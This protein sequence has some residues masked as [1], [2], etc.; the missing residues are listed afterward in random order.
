MSDRFHP[1]SMGA[2]TDWV[3]DELEGAGSV[4]GIPRELFFRP[5]P[6]DPFGLEV[7]GRSLESP[8]GVAAGPHTQM[9]Q[10]IVVAWLCGARFIELKTIQTLDELD[11]NK[12]CIDIQDE[13]Y[14]VE[15]SQELKVHESFDEYLRAWVL[16]HALH[17]KLG[18]PG[19]APGIIFNMSVGYD[20]AGIHRPNVQWYLDVMNDASAYLPAY[21]ELVAGR[22]PELGNISV[23]ERLSDNITLSTMHGCPPGEIESIVT[24]LITERGLHTSVKCNPTLLGPQEVR[25]IVNDDLGYRDVPIPDE[26]FGHDLTWDDG[27]PMFRRLR[28]LADEH[29]VTFGL[30]L[31]NTLEVENW[32]TVFPD[33]PTMYMS[34]RALHAVTV[35]VARMVWEEFGGDLLLSFAG[36]ADCFNVP[37]LLASGMTT[38]TV[39]SDLLK[40][41]GYLRLLQYVET[42]RSAM[43][44]VG[45]SDLDDLVCRSALNAHRAGVAGLLGATA[46][47]ARPEAD[48]L[49]EHLAGARGRVL[50]E[51]RRW[52]V[53]R[54]VDGDIVDA[55]RRACAIVN[56]SA[57]ADAVRTERRLHKDTYQTGHSKTPRHLGL[58]DCIAAPCVDE[59]PVDQKVPQYMVAVRDGDFDRA[60]ALARQD[61]PIPTILGHVCDHLCEHTCIRTHYDEPLAI[62]HIK[63]FIM[64][65]EPAPSRPDEEA[66]ADLRV[67]VIGAGPAG[68][69]AASELAAAGAS[70]TVFE[71]HPY[72]G[73]MVGGA[74]PS[75]RLPQPAIDA[76][77]ARLDLLGVEFRY[78][79]AA[80]ADF[81]LS[82]LRAEGFG[83]VIVAVG[84]QLAKRLGLEGEDAEGVVDG[85]SFLRSV[86]EGTPM[87]IGKRVV[88]IGAGDTAMDC[89]RT[90][91]RLGADVSIVYRRTIDQMPADR[92][93]IAALLDEGIEV[94][95][96]AVPAALHV[97]GGRLTGM[98]CVR[99]EYRGD[100]DASGRK[101]P[102][103][104]EGSELDMAV[105]TMLLA[106]SQHAVLDFFGDD[107]PEL[108]RRGYLATDPDTLET[109]VPGVYAGGDAGAH[110]P[111]SIVIAAA[112]GKAMAAAIMARSALPHGTAPEAHR[113]PTDPVAL[114]ARRAHREYRVPIRELP[115]A[116]RRSFDTAVLSYTAEEA[117]AEA[118]R[119]L[120]CHEMCSICVGVCPNLA[121]V[122][123]ASVPFEAD[124][125]TMAFTDGGFVVDHSSR[126]R[127]EQALQVA[128]LTDFCN[129][130]GNCVTFC[131]TAGAP[132]RDK[133]RLYLDRGDFEAQADN[134]F[135]LRRDAGGVIMEGRW[136]GETHRVTL[137]GDLTYETPAARIRV[138]P[139]TWQVLDGSADP[140]VARSVSLLP[141]AVM[142]AL[143]SGLQGSVPHLPADGGRREGRIAHPG[144][145]E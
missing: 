18:F 117:R 69:G 103:E 19:E 112:D 60:V 111:A 86:R 73:G 8:F 61:N 106:I 127:V 119:C 77:I 83:P 24:Y 33:D 100:R 38:V 55:L 84:A 135:M 115:V 85:I 51:A 59:C 144:Y 54:A 121:I 41:G 109:S 12:P 14:N 32:R 30:K 56:L 90:A 142:Y 31:S 20:L 133:P 62:R 110:G 66:P 88:V 118:A 130:C 28:A 129:E 49:T 116:D 25:G 82:D 137:N 1:I 91:W 58:F 64:D 36:G 35:N 114:L 7:Y 11:I 101:I 10:N 26:A 99:M 43:S 68:L 52:A 125:P 22:Y 70:V 67:A 131:P 92:E 102:H 79:I 47:L 65:R 74:I 45:A 95:E 5:A 134:A 145:E 16:I 141:A 71:Q 124:V 138:D 42:T 29:G 108:T 94:V 48:A 104:I 123:Y 40:S 4:F 53:E 46:G 89:A 75:Y 105:D 6:D 72:P 3:F 126:F 17:H 139:H 113:P 76:D 120:D 143:L 132:Y 34:G 50:D 37:D 15:W 9:A 140:E 93:E 23:P 13:G 97:E 107:R 136:S 57:Y 98:T 39:C 81:T 80:G 128:V 44:G 122:T 87:G 21:I 63:R 2:L 27:A 78:G 96:L